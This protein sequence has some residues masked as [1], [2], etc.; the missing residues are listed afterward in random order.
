MCDE[1][2]FDVL[3]HELRKARIDHEQESTRLRDMD[4]NHP[5]NASQRCRVERAAARHDALMEAA[6][7]V[8]VL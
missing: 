4:D 6:E 2:T 7:I 3:A 5:Q 8:G 1:K